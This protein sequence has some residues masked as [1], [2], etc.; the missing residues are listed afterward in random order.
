MKSVKFSIRTLIKADKDAIYQ[1]HLQK[2]SFSRSFPPWEKASILSIEDL[3]GRQV[4][5]NVSFDRFF[6]KS[7]GRPL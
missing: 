4:R 1:W 2:A 5:L 6:K 7:K 3:P